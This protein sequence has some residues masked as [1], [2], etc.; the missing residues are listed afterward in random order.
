MS[1]ILVYGYPSD[2]NFG[3]PSII[4][5]F[6][7]LV[8]TCCPDDEM[9]CYESARLTPAVVSGYDFK[10][11]RF[12]YRSMLAFWKDWLLW[13]LFRR[14]PPGEE[15]R[16]FWCDFAAARVV[17][18]LFGICFCSGVGKVKS[19]VSLSALKALLGRF[20]PSLAARLSGKRSVK[21]TCSYG[22]ATRTFERKCARWAARFFF[23]AM[24][25]REEVSRSALRELTRGRVDAPVAPDVANLMPVP[26]GT[27]A[28][29][30]VG[31]VV[32]YK[33][34]QEWKRTDV[35]YIDAMAALA[36]HA[37]ER[38]GCRVVLIPN[39]DGTLDGRRLKRGDTD[40]ARDIL[41]RLAGTDGVAL[42]ETL[43]RAALDTKAAL[44]R[45]AMV[46]SPRYHSCVAAL[47]A[48]VPLLTLG[49]HEK[50]SA[51][52]AL[53]GQERWMV[54]AEDCSGTRLTDC[55]DALMSNRDV[56]SAEI[57]SK[58]GMVVDAVVRSGQIML[59]HGSESQNGAG[60]QSRLAILTRT[61][62]TA[63]VG[64]CL[65]FAA[66]PTWR[67]PKR[68]I[69]SR[70]GVVTLQARI[71]ENILRKYK[72]KDFFVDLNGGMARL[73]LR[74]ICNERIRCRNGMLVEPDHGYVRSSFGDGIASFSR[75]L[76]GKGI[77][78]MFVLIPCK[79]DV[80]GRIFP[81]GWSRANRNVSAQ[82][83]ARRLKDRANVNVLDLVPEFAATE[84]AVARNFFRTDHHWR[85]RAALRAAQLV[86]NALSKALQESKLVD[87]D[88][89]RS[90][91]WIWERLPHTFLGSDGRRTGAL[92]VGEDEFEYA[93]PKFMSIIQVGENLE[94]VD[95]ACQQF[96][97]RQLLIS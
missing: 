33:M 36:R 21:S 52:T 86:A 55:F 46:V 84:E 97:I 63:A 34:E 66:L 40:V 32:S 81:E 71:H 1:K 18:N 67:H 85:F 5:G 2:W 76:D 43:G 93:F 79:V 7:E 78:F 49:W 90:E 73:A 26:E 80:S 15:R 28:D 89:L 42:F 51:L 96:I 22:P 19:P 53:Y 38:H 91:N 87:Q 41:V 17:V 20:S 45:C 16:V 77:P 6:R 29:D 64:A 75:W 68:L 35:S 8:R 12:P 62:F 44:A 48:G 59:G 50:Y 10:T 30:L 57:R 31:L 88:N 39:Q 74:R 25:A 61:A 70:P 27:R 83:E 14:F 58:K 47:S 54:P 37:R 56:V 94:L 95:S 4:L 11:R 23:D 13:R 69:V 24:L 9:V 60:R 65:C 3:G 82:M 72:F 92:F